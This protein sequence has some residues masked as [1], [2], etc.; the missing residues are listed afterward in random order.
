MKSYGYK[1]EMA[2]KRRTPPMFQSAR[3]LQHFRRSVKINLPLDIH[4]RRIGLALNSVDHP[5]S[6]QFTALAPGKGRTPN[7]AFAAIEGEAGGPGT[8]AAK[9]PQFEVGP[10]NGSSWSWQRLPE[11]KDDESTLGQRF[12]LSF[13]C[14]RNG[15]EETLLMTV[16]LGG[17]PLEN[18]SKMIGDRDWP[19]NH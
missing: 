11:C 12:S 17:D 13:M 15:R 18:R 9:G 2:E 1:E 8:R 3:E 10:A 5:N 6:L 7:G 4:C 16:S 19:V 14:D